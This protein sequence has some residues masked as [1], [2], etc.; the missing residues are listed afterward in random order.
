MRSILVLLAAAAAKHAV[1]SKL[2]ASRDEPETTQ[3]WLAHLQG[4]LGDEVLVHTLLELVRN[5]E[6]CEMFGIQVIVDDPT[7]DQRELARRGILRLEPTQKWTLSPSDR[8]R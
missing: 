8:S 2:L 5:H 7:P 4:M 3:Q 1:P 6:R